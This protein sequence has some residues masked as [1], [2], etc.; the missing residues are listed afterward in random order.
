M[1]LV[2]FKVGSLP[3]LVEVE[4]MR[5]MKNVLDEG[6]HGMFTVSRVLLSH[7]AT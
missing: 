7:D 4:G 6:I 3:T 1:N 2:S 5:Y